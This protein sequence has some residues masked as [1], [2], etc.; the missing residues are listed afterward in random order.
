[1]KIGIKASEARNLSYDSFVRK[2]DR[3]IKEAINLAKTEIE[4][5]VTYHDQSFITPISNELREQG[6]DASMTTNNGH[7]VL[8]IKW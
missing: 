8:L 6:F 7:K 4:L 1:M 2:I 3:S 5:I